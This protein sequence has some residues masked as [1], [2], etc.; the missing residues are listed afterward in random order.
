MKL[1]YDLHLHSCLSPC[2]SEDMTPQ[3]VCRMARLNGLDL[4]ALTDHNTGG[5]LKAFDQAAREH[6]LLFLPGMELCT[7][8][9]VHLLAYFLSLEAALE[10]DARLPHLRGSMKNRPDYFGQQTLVDHRDSVL[11]Q[12]EAFLLGALATSLE[13]TVSWITSFHGVAVP[14][15]IHRSYGLVQ[16]LGFIPQSAGFRAVEAG[17]KD[18]IDENYLVLHSSDAHELGLIAQKEHLISA[19]KNLDSIISTLQYGITV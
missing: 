19:E 15:H 17:P 6:G 4:I 7:A 3:N 10:A 11:G 14:A 1:A 18:Q 12:E 5:N 8:E 13:E 9:E 2:A 16:V